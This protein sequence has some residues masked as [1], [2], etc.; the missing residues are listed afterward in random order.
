MVHVSLTSGTSGHISPRSAVGMQDTDLPHG[1]RIIDQCDVWSYLTQQDGKNAGHR[2]ATWCTR[3][4]RMQDTDLPHGAR[5]ID[6]CDVWS[7]LTRSAVRMQDTA[8]ELEV[9]DPLQVLVGLPCCPSIYQRSVS[10]N[11]EFSAIPFRKTCPLPYPCA[12]RRC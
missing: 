2:P 11:L 5:I 9:D 4:V 6:Q 12:L 10:F 3:T 8:A 1:A 7:Y